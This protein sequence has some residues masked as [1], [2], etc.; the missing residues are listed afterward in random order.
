MSVH[1]SLV[2]VH[3]VSMRARACACDNM[4][5]AV[6]ALCFAWVHRVAVAAHGVALISITRVM[7][8]AAPARLSGCWWVGLGGAHTSKQ[9]QRVVWRNGL[10]VCVC[11]CR[12]CLIEECT[13]R[14]NGWLA[15]VAP[16]ERPSHDV[17]HCCGRC[18]GRCRA[19]A[20]RAWTAPRKQFTDTCEI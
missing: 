3:V 11:G 5:C 12:R 8:G 1:W 15:C 18:C 9:L 14:P 6:A 2:H 20:M 10:C 19:P 13:V 17:R 4:P 7:A 16:P